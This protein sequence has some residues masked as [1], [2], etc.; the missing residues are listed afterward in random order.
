M[1]SHHLDGVLVIERLSF[2]T[3]WSRSSFLN[4]LY[5]NDYA[6]YYVCLWEDKVVGYAGMWI[7]LDEAHLTNIAVHPGFR[8]CGIGELLLDT[9]IKEAVNLGAARMTL[10][11]RIS[12]IPA[13]RLYE[14][15]GFV[16]SGIRRGYY[17]DTQEDAL[18]MWKTLCEKG[19][20]DGKHH[21]GH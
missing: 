10:E 14:K 11:V 13:Q 15:K 12:N 18:I 7:I 20:G 17:T 8:R 19:G 2:P 5:T 3:P 9:L 4:E 6:F 21:P 1:T 16:R